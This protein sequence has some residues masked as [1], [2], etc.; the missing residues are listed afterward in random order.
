MAERIGIRTASIHYHFLTK[1]D[2]GRVVIERYA[3]K[4]A[5]LGRMAEAREGDP[6]LVLSSYLEPYIEFAGSPGR[7]C[8]CGALAGEYGALPEEM[9]AFFS[10]LQGGCCWPG[11]RAVGGREQPY[12]SVAVI[13]AVLRG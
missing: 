2:L 7:I 5:E 1:A 13:K 6:W 4:L 8:L 9:Q 3:A 11:G 10:A 12:A